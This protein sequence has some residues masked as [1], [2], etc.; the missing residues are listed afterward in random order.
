[1]SICCVAYCGLCTG[2][3]P[4]IDGDWDGGAGCRVAFPVV[5]CDR[6]TGSYPR[7]SLL[8]FSQLRQTGCRSSHWSIC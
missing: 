4:D 5:V 3:R 6:K 8:D 1:M 7:H 2:E